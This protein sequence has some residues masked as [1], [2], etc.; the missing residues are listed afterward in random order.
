M[1]KCHIKNQNPKY[2]HLNP[3]FGNPNPGFGHPNPRFRGC[4]QRRPPGDNKNIQVRWDSWM[5]SIPWI[6][7]NPTELHELHWIP[8]TLEH[9]GF[10]SEKWQTICS[11][12]FAYVWIKLFS[13]IKKFRWS[14]YI[15]FWGSIQNR[16]C[17]MLKCSLLF[18]WYHENHL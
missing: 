7:W 12:G 13:N 15:L 18:L 10:V 3:R 11:L 5:P 16:Q 8:W 9:H 1:S 4:Q 6:P 17:H 2:G 14:S